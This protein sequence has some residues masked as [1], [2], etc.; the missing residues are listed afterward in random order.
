MP[1]VK[2]TNCLLAMSPK[3][4][5]PPQP[6]MPCIRCGAC[7]LACP[8]VLQPHELYWYAQVEELRQG[9]GIPPV[10]LHRMRLLCLRLPV[11]HPAG[12]L[13]PFRQV[14]DPRPRARKGARPTRPANATNSASSAK[15]ARKP[16]KPPSSRPRPPKPR[17]SW[18]RKTPPNKTLRR[19]RKSVLA[20]RHLPARHVSRRRHP[21]A[22]RQYRT[23][24]PTSWR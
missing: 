20:R 6:E 15:N 1:I 5:P 10:R 2:A 8:M 21:P 18:R 23:R 24:L 22:R 12:R 4:F 19:P 14:R 16:R 3:L 7:T 9:A 17:P 13:L 11:A